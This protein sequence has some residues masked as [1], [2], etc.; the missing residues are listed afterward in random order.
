MQRPDG[1]RARQ[2]LLPGVGEDAACWNVEDAFGLLEPLP[3]RPCRGCCR[4]WAAALGTAGSSKVTSAKGRP[5]VGSVGSCLSR[6][7]GPGE[8]SWR[9]LTWAV[10]VGTQPAE[11]SRDHRE[12]AHCYRRGATAGHQLV[13]PGMV[14][15]PW[16]SRP[17]CCG[18]D[19]GGGS[20]RGAFVVGGD[21]DGGAG[22]TRLCV[23]PG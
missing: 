22:C 23:A 21:S 3:T 6:V 12:G 15:A 1:L 7:R 9:T 4:E 17:P 14:R 10:L 18:Q 20:A 5:G 2:P 8:G 11:H 19:P 13:G 16:R